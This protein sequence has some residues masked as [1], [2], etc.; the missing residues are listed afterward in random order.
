MDNVLNIVLFIID[1]NYKNSKIVRV[2]KIK[3]IG[4][5]IFNLLYS[6]QKVEQNLKKVDLVL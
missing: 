4:W 6:F 1:I 2:L 3:F 5:L